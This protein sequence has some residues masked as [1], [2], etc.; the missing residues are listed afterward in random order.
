VTRS[1]LNMIHTLQPAMPAYALVD[2]DP[3][4]INIFRCYKWGSAALEHEKALTLPSLRWL[5]VK[6]NDL[7][8]SPGQGKITTELSHGSSH[9]EP[10]PAPQGATHSAWPCSWL[11]SLTQ[12]DQKLA[13]KLLGDLTRDEASGVH[14][15]EDISEAREELQMM[16]MMNF[17]AEM[18]SMNDGGS[19]A[20]YLERKLVEVVYKGALPSTMGAVSSGMITP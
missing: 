13:V 17:K 20:A 2:F 12:R 8:N 1:F 9:R 7:R 6:S 15:A 3:D 11:S 4:G 19:I 5:G 10:T 18:Q 14:G 16:L